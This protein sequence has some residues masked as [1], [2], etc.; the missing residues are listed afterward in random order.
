MREILKQ[1]EVDILL[2]SAGN[3]EA[4]LAEGAFSET[5]VQPAF[6]AN[7]TTDVWANIRG[8]TYDDTPSRPYRGAD[9]AFAQADLCLYS[10][11]FNNDADADAAALNAYATFRRE[12]RERGL[13]HFLEVFNP[14][15]TGAI[16]PETVGAY[17]VD[18]ILRLMASLTQAERPE[19]LKVAYNGPAAMEELAGHDPSL[20]VG[21]LGGSGATHRDTFELI[22]QGERHGARLAL[23]GR[24]INQA[25]DQ[26]SLIAWMRRVADREATPEEAVRGYHAGLAQRGLAPDRDLGDD[27]AIT[28]DVLR[29]AA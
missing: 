26:C 11:T 2:A 23:F 5:S 16:E 13:R 20:P 4:L 25:E 8:G 17:V 18:C 27:L 3:I 19:F 22:A 28:D 10:I 12:A 7:E 14:N 6:R 15:R 29:N 9:L 21:V 24:K 1:D